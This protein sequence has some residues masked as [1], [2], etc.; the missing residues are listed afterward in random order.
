F[1]RLAAV[2]PML[3]VP[4]TAAEL[5]ASVAGGDSAPLAGIQTTHQTDLALSSLA[6]ADRGS[7]LRLGRW[8]HDGGSAVLR[9][10]ATGIL[11]KTSSADMLDEVALTLGRDSEVRDLYVWALSTR[12]GYRTGAL[13]A[14]VLN[15][16]DA[17]ARW[18]AAWLLGQDGSPAARAA[19]TVALRREQLRENVRAIGL[20]L[21]GADPCM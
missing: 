17:G 5:M 15:P 16:R 8:M 2:S 3:G 14:E 21:N 12:V 11:A 1:L 20:M 9:V 19:L 7:L 4:D 10:N 18:C 6:G 13:A